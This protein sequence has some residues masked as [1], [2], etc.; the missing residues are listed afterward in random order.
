MRKR[1]KKRGAGE[2]SLVRLQRWPA[3]MRH[4]DNCMVRIYSEEHGA[5]WRPEG[6]GYT[7]DGLEAGVYVFEDAFKCTRH[8]GPEKRIVYRLADAQ[9]GGTL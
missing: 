8:C 6:A 2:E 7:C 1:F 3:L 9:Q 5:Y 4:W